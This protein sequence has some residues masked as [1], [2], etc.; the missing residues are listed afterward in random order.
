[1]V[2]SLNDRGFYGTPIFSFKRYGDVPISFYQVK[3]QLS[4]GRKI[5]P[6]QYM[7]L[8]QRRKHG[9]FHAWVQSHPYVVGWEEE[10]SGQRYAYFF[11]Q[12]K[13]GFSYYF[14]Q[15]CKSTKE[16]IK[17]RKFGSSHSYV[18]LDG[19][20]GQIPD[21]K[22]FDKVLFLAKG[23]GLAA[24]LLLMRELLKCHDD[25]SARIRRLTLVWFLESRRTCYP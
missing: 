7:N 8:I 19:P 3:I 23:I 4:T 15:V 18:L 20:Y 16:V 21:L 2:F 13:G 1:M 12:C 17:D 22:S 10:K 24:Q 14:Q 5:G 9:W 11:I 25:R 6:G